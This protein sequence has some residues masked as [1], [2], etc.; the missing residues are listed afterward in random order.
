MRGLTIV[1][2]SASRERFRTA[3]NMALATAA[4]GGRARVFLDGIAVAILR[5][6]IVDTDD[7]SYEAAGLPTLAALCDEA[8]DAGVGL[9]LCQSGLAL[10][11]KEAGDYDS[12]VEYAGMVS[13][14]A[15]LGDDRLVIA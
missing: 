11:G 8:I 10:I 1:I 13:I 2:A 7:G 5:K 9:I 6:P 3:L 15:E 14:L 4:L 12:R